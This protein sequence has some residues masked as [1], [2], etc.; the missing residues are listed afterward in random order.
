MISSK[1]YL[2][3]SIYVILERNGAKSKVRRAWNYW[4][5]IE[6]LPK[7]Y[8]ISPYHLCF[9]RRKIEEKAYLTPK[10]KCLMFLSFSFDNLF[11]KIFSL[12]LAF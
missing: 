2:R 5:K 10:V 4:F 1:N 11:R 8:K 3:T 7:I 9:K 6:N 12:E